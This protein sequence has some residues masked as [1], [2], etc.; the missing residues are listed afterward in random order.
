[1]QYSSKLT[2]QIA[3]T[4]LGIKGLRFD[5]LKVELFDNNN[6]LYIYKVCK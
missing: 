4:M 5:Y 3:G 2:Y 6:N 1:M